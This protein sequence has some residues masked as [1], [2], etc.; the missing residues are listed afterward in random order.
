MVVMIRLDHASRVWRGR[1]YQHCL[2]TAAAPAY[3]QGTLPLRSALAWRGQ[4]HL[5]QPRA[6]PQLIFLPQPTYW[7]NFQT[8][9]SQTCI[10][11][12]C[13]DLFIWPTLTC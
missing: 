4:P 7:G 10:V 9:T 5:T 6:L 2:T 11:G 12:Y 13:I 3:W 8:G 1:G